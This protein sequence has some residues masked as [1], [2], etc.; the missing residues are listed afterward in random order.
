VHRVCARPGKPVNFVPVIDAD[1]R[2]WYKADSLWQSHDDRYDADAVLVI[3]GPEAVQGIT[4]A[5]DE[6]VGELLRRFVATASSACAP[7][8]TS[9]RPPGTPS[10]APGCRRPPGPRASPS[11]AARTGRCSP[12]GR[13]VAGQ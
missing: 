3:P 9:P 5:V 12:L 8:A 1:V 10:T 6:P 11:R 7:P 4:P 13:R 2:R